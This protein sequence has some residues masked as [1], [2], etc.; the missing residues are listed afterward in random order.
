MVYE[1]DILGVYIQSLDGGLYSVDSWDNA[2]EANGVAVISENSRFVI[3][4][5]N[6]GQYSIS[7]DDFA[8]A[9]YNEY[10]TPFTTSTDAKNDYKGEVN[11][12]NMIKVLSDTGKAAGFCKNFTFPNGKKGKLL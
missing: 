2:K 10:M 3:S 1:S 4:K 8:G 7:S 9:K 6:Y 12:N 5:N 11:T